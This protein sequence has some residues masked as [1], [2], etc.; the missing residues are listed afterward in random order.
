[1]KIWKGM[2]T[3]RTGNIKLV[4]GNKAFNPNVAT[5]IM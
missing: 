2:E 3:F 4:K 1:M 5:K